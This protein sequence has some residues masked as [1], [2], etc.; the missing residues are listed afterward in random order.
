M[1]CKRDA[2]L[3]SLLQHAKGRPSYGGFPFFFFFIAD[4]STLHNNV[5]ANNKA[6]NGSDSIV[7]LDVNVD[8]KICYR[9]VFDA[10]CK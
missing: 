1:R 6:V 10:I 8:K 7:A 5:R 2:A 9:K 4:D 3:K